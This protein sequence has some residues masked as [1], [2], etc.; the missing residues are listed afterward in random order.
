MKISQTI[1]SWIQPV[2]SGWIHWVK[3]HWSIFWLCKLFSARSNFLIYV[4]PTQINFFME[5]WHLY[6]F[7]YLVAQ[8]TGSHVACWFLIKMW[9][10]N[11]PFNTCIYDNLITEDGCFI[12][13]VN[14]MAGACKLNFSTQYILI[15]YDL[16]H[17]PPK[18]QL[19][20]IS[21]MG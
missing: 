3:Y 4:T 21:I 14:N 18:Y 12:A 20:C 17:F 16:L 5:S 11:F 19:F 2:K 13:S 6:I 15:Y 7:S 8:T 9:N 10:G 1:F